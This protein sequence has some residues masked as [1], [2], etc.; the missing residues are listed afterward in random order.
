MRV[1]SFIGRYCRPDELFSKAYQTFSIGIRSG[2]RDG[3]RRLCI[4]PLFWYPWIRLDT[5]MPCCIVGHEKKFI[6]IDTT[7]YANIRQQ[8]CFNVL[9]YSHSSGWKYIEQRMSTDHNINAYYDR[10]RILVSFLYVFRSMGRTSLMPGEL[11]PIIR[12][13]TELTFI[14]E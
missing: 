8:N 7:E 3:Q 1:A 4:S 10:R 11:L 6:I 5:L 12:R 2:E 9:L 13:E 14:W